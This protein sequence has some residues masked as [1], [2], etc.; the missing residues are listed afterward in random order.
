MLSPSKASAFGASLF[1][2]LGP[3]SAKHRHV[4]ANLRMV[5]PDLDAATIQAHARGVWRNIGSM[6]AEYPHLENLMGKGGEVRYEIIYKNQNPDFLSAS[7]PYIF[8]A[9]HLGNIYFSADAICKSGFPVDLVYSPLTNH[10]VDRCILEY[11]S[12]LDCGF[13]TKQNALRP[14]LKALKQ[15]RSVG[16]H[17]DVRVDEG[18]LIPLCGEDAMTTMAPAF[19]SVKT[20]VDII[21]VHTERLPDA[22]FR[23]T[24]FPALEP[25]PEGCSTDEAIN[26]LTAQMNRVIGG[27]IQEHPDQWMCTKRR[28]PK[29]AMRECGVYRN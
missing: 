26:L 13:I 19:L 7:K 12:V 6:I 10:L 20:G 1:G 21:P 27:L 16:I 11:I 2:W 3:R 18:E 22:R 5:R 24:M 8:V 29:Q 23:V 14:M 17:V 25:A 15:G 9:A 4:I 28:W